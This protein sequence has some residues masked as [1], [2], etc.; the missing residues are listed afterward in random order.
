ML[1]LREAEVFCTN[2]IAAL[3]SAFCAKH[4]EFKRCEGSAFNFCEGLNLSR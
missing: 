4:E 2:T 3:L 1:F